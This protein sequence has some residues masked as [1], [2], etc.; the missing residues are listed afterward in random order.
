MLCTYML[1]KSIYEHRNIPHHVGYFCLFGV[2]MFDC[3]VSIDNLKLSDKI[4]NLLKAND[5]YTVDDF[6][7]F[8]I[9]IV[10]ENFD[11]TFDDWCDVVDAFISLK[12]IKKI[13]DPVLLSA[14][15]KR[16][17]SVFCNA[18][19]INIFNEK[20]VVYTI[21]HGKWTHDDYIYKSIAHGIVFTDKDDARKLAEQISQNN[22]SKIIEST[23]NSA[24]NRIYIIHAMSPDKKDSVISFN[25]SIDKE[26]ILEL[27]LDKK[28]HIHP[29]SRAHTLAVKAVSRINKIYDYEIATLAEL[30]CDT[31]AHTVLEVNG[32]DSAIDKY[33]VSY[34]DIK[35]YVAELNKKIDHENSNFFTWGRND[36]INESKELS[37]KLIESRIATCL[38]MRENYNEDASITPEDISCLEG[39]IEGYRI[40]IE[41]Q[42]ECKSQT[43]SIKATVALIDHFGFLSQLGIPQEAVATQIVKNNC[44]IDVDL[45]TSLDDLNMHYDAYYL[46]SNSRNSHEEE[47]EMFKIQK[48]FYET[49][50]QNLRFITISRNLKNVFLRDLFILNEMEE[51]EDK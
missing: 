3:I 50:K 15:N 17:N 48:Q 10:K 25:N 49:H 43:D 19:L 46:L 41:T 37:L 2:I 34:V 21:K 33:E 20:Y 23:I 14:F 28:S 4:K 31:E 13:Q 30:I 12:S 5:I 38:D 6:V 29:T 40:A 18:L 8:G 9:K 45:F 51:K 16:I 35:K 11:L 7:E 27:M 1:C 44:S 22:Q 24:K 36:A 26:N 39:R 47:D 42:K 32:N